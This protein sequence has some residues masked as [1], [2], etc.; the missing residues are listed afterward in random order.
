MGWE[1]TNGADINAGLNG[2]LTILLHLLQ[3]LRNRAFKSYWGSI[4]R[5]AT[6]WVWSVTGSVSEGVGWP[7]H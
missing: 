6:G 4:P 2:L 1:G 7:R 3:G 5:Q